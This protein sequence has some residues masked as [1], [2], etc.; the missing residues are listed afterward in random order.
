MKGKKVHIRELSLR[1]SG[2]TRAE[3]RRL[4]ELVAQRL[5]ELTRRTTQSKT[6]SEVSIK[7]DS[8]TRSVDRLASEVATRIGRKLS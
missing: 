2:L 1:A 7:F 8:T 6:I 3:G 5:A 4:G